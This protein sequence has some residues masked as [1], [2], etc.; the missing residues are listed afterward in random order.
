MSAPHRTRQDRGRRTRIVRGRL[1]MRLLPP[2]DG[3]YAPLITAR[4]RWAADDPHAVTL[5]IRTR[6]NHWVTWC[7]ALDLLRDGCHTPVGIGDVSVIP[8]PA[9]PGI[10]ELILSSD[11]GHAAFSFAVAELAPF[12]S[13]AGAAMSGGV[14]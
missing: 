9:R 4:L 5:D 13:R 14:R 10:A 11:A 8:H 3:G 12:L 6:P 7:V 1:M 2:G